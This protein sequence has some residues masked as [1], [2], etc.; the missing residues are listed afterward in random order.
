MIESA[1]V[2]LGQHLNID[3]VLEGKIDR[4]VKRYGLSGD[5]CAFYADWEDFCIDWCNPPIS[6]T[7]TEARKLLRNNPGE[8]MVLPYQLGIIRFVL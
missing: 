4:H 8:F 7:R 3:N 5:V 2:Y 6:Y 1:K